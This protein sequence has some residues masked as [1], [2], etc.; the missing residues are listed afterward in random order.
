VGR[1]RSA[2]PPFSGSNPEAA[3]LIQFV[4][5]GSWFVARTTATQRQFV[6]RGSPLVEKA[7]NDTKNRT[8]YTA[9]PKRECG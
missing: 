4:A 8:R 7:Q 3:F 9:I 1:Q 5:R 2:K 6:V